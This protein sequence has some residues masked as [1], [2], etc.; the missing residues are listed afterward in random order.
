MPTKKKFQTVKEMQDKIDEYFDNC[1]NRIQSVYSKAQDAVIEIINPEPYT[2]EGLALS[3]EVDRETLLNY[4]KREG[5]EKYF[6]TVKRAKLKVQQSVVIHSFEG[7]NAAGS[8]FNLKNN[9]G[10]KD[11]TEVDLTTNIETRTDEELQEM[12]IELEKKA[13]SGK[14][15]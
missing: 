9:F 7:K 1:D 15:L 4:E 6:G 8:I 5:Y 13:A 2:I 11:K 3:L 12:L 14:T 10:Y